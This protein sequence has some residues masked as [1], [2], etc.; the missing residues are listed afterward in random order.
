MSERW[1]YR[2]WTLDPRDVDK[3]WAHELDR[4]GAQGWELVACTSVGTNYVVAYFKRRIPDPIGGYA[5]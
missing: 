3:K 2:V 4:Q 5:T 1:E